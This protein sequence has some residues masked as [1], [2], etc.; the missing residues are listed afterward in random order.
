MKFKQITE[1]LFIALIAVWGFYEI[2][3]Y[4]PLAIGASNTSS[5]QV[6]QG[7]A[8]K[9]RL[10]KNEDKIVVIDG[11]PL[12]ISDL[13]DNEIYDAQVKLY[14]AYLKKI[15]IYFFENSNTRPDINISEEDMRALYEQS[16]STDQP[17][18][19]VKEQ[20]RN[21]LM[22]LRGRDAYEG[23]FNEA[24]NKGKVKVLME[25]PE[26]FLTQ[27]P[28]NGGILTEKGKG[29]TVFIEFS[30]F[31]CPFCFRVQNTLKALKEKYKVTYYYRHFPLSIHKEAHLS[32]VA[33]ECANE[34]GKFDEMH[35]IL[36]ANQ[37]DQ[38]ENDLKRYAKEIG[39]ADYPEFE[40]CLADPAISARVDN[41]IST[42]SNLGI[43]GT[44]TFYIGKLSADGK[45]MRGQAVSG[46]QDYS[47]FAQMLDSL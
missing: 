41:D 37:K 45:T 1:I 3:S 32:A 15:K 38:F 9:I 42:G 35:E 40:R 2:Y 4:S 14:D 29:D 46:A 19:T 21:Y 8:E 11:K 13:I 20:I 18:E 33:S 24:K 5:K 30:D 16:G 23:A 7:K 22:Q 12:A 39:I 34:Q 26:P 17:Y 10:F 43:S 36:F 25:K 28:M 6:T 44:P 47:V 27:V 31:Q